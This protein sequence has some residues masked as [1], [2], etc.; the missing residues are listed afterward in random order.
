ME[1]KQRLKQ[2]GKIRE[3]SEPYQETES[4]STQP[5][6]EERYEIINGVRYDLKP[7]P[8]FNHQILVTQLWNGIYSTCYPNGTV[9]VAPMDVHLDKDNIVQPDVIFIS[10]ENSHIVQN[11]KIEGSPDLLVEILSPSTSKKDK[12]VKKELYERF[13]IKE[14]WIVDPVHKII[15]QFVLENQKYVL[16]ASY[17]EGGTLA[18]P[19]IYFYIYRPG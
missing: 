12:I 10:N 4:Q 19:L 7:S 2:A 8:T 15:D 18:S 17:G 5:L 9:V 14:Y 16:S 6:I 13:G 1:N 3:Q 11:Q